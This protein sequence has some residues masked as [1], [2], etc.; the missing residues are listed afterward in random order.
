[1]LARDGN[2]N[3]RTLGYM[4]NPQITEDEKAVV[5]WCLDWYRKLREKQQG[6]SRSSPYYPRPIAQLERLAELCEKLEQTNRT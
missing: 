6:W 3:N 1:M 2:V 5:D 4:G